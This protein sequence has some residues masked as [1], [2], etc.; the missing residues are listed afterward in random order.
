MLGGIP[1][2]SDI[3]KTQ[4][5]LDALRACNMSASSVKTWLDCPAKFFYAKVEGLKAEKEVSESLDSGMLGNVLHRTMQ[6]LYPAGTRVDAAFL[7]GLRHSVKRIR[8]TV[9]RNICVELKTLEVSGRNLVLLDIVCSYVDAIIGADLSRVAAEG[10]FAVIGTEKFVSLPIGGF[11]FVGY[12]DRLR[13]VDYKTGRVGPADLT[14]DP[15]TEDMPQIGLQ[16]YLYKRMLAPAA[17]GK[18][19]DGA[20]YQPAAILGGGDIYRLDLDAPYC[21]RMDADLDTV[22]SQISDLSV[23]WTRTGDLKKCEYCDF[24]AICGR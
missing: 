22:L 4:E 18:E 10:P 16:L 23:P 3:P 20:I 12:I 5:H 1:A 17:H 8:E 7:E 9:E 24:R 14:F 2:E 6:E 11:T 13:V 15:K 21:A 19:I